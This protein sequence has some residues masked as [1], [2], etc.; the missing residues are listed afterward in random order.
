MTQNALRQLIAVSPELPDRMSDCNHC[1]GLSRSRLLH[2]AAAEAGRGLPAIEPGMP[3]PA[4]TGLSR[5]SFVAQGA[6]RDARRLRRVAARLSAFEEGI[7]AA[8][9]GP[10]Q[11]VLVSVFLEG[12][13]DALSV[14]SPQGDPLYRKLR[15]TAR[16]LPAA[17]PL[18]EDDRLYWHP[19]GRRARAALRRAEGDRH[20]G[21]RLHACRPVPLHV[22]PL[23]GGRR[24]EH[25]PAHGLARPLPRP[26][27]HDGQ[28]AAG[29]LARRHASPPALA[30]AKVPVAVDRRPRPVR[31]LEQP[32]LG[33]GR[34]SACSTRSAR[35]GARSADPALTRP[36]ASPRRSTGCATSSCR[37]RHGRQARA[38]RARSPYPKSD[39]AVPAAAR[40]PR[41]DARRRPAAARRRADARPGDV[42]HALRPGR[43]ARAGPAADGRLAARVPARPR[44]ARP[45]RPR[46]RARVV[47]VRP[48]RAGE[49]LQRHRPRRGRRRLPHR[50][51][52]ARDRWS[53]SSPVSTSGLDDDGNVSATADFRGVYASLLE[54]WL[55][56]DAAR[57]HPGR[58][59]V[60]AAGARQ[61]I[62]AASAARAR[63]GRRAGV[64]LRALAPD[65]QGRPRDHRAPQRG[66]GRARP[67]AAARRRHA[68]A[69][70]GR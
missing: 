39:D 26:R 32:R 49:R 27:R 16:A 29:P 58:R 1:D 3:L 19:G 46:A 18:A 42:R 14:L 50:H 22:A 20:A 4:G 10:P 30:T 33:R 31:L 23:L 56:V 28:P 53:A 15:P 62:A 59:D 25:E 67:A 35:S 48:P 61:V 57:G 40:R 44:G 47:G 12:G 37:S 9:T 24:D 41:G 43:R 5:R 51:A 69:T 38:S 34:D 54:Q 70:R 11:P 55:G 36:Q 13:A 8:A 6:R 66:R 60:P 17:P 63:P 21:D 2:R 7:A 65:D 45:R 64:P 52:R 68:R